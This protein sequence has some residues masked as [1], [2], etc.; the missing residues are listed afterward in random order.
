MPVTN[1]VIVI[2]DISGFTEFFTQV[3]IEHA[4]EI[5]DQLL[6]KMIEPMH[7]YLTINEIEGDA[8]L[9]YRSDE[10]PDRQELLDCCHQIFTA[11]EQEKT[12]QIEERK[13][14][15]KACTGIGKLSV[16][17]VGHYGKLAITR[18]QQFEKAFGL[19]MIIAHRLLKNSLNR[20][21]YL[22]FTDAL[23]TKCAAA[24]EKV[25]HWEQGEESYDQVGTVSFS[26]T[27]LPLDFPASL[28]NT[29]LN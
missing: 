11:F 7:P 5:I 13:C 9:G 10:Q 3:E 19:D 18:V 4:A 20:R 14:K 21:Q 24:T 17:I 26:Y 6:V 1:A 23:L 15:C 8:L 22:L 25:T 28:A 16:K 2:P 27:S 12:R 29:E